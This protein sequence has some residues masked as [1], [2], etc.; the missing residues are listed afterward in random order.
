[1]LVRPPFG[2]LRQIIDHLVAVGVK[3]VRAVFMIQDAR[4]IQLVI[5]VTADV[6]TA[7]DQQDARLVLAGK[8][9]G[10]DRPGKT[11]ADDQII[12]MGSL[13]GR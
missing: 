7:I 4:I 2:E 6:R 8:P 13:V 12:V 10:Q 3:D 11:G 5:G 9:L 1:M